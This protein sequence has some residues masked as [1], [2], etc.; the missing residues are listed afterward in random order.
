[1]KKYNLFVQILLVLLCIFPL[2]YA[3]LT[4]FRSG[5]TDGAAITGIVESLDISPTQSN[6]IL[7]IFKQYLTGNVESSGARILSVIVSN[8]I[9]IY[10]AFVFVEFLIFVPK[11][12]LH[13]LRIFARKE[14]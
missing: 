6:E 13:L 14:D 12:A 11:L 2:L 3:T 9:F 1:M 8:S 7:L 5:V 10:V 4:G